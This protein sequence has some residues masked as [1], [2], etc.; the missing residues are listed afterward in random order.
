MVGHVTPWSGETRSQTAAPACQAR[1]CASEAPMSRASRVAPIVP[2]LLALYHLGALA[3]P[4]RGSALRRNPARPAAPPENRRAVAHP[5]DHHPAARSPAQR[6]AGSPGRA[7]RPGSGAGGVAGA[8]P[9][10]TNHRRR[11]GAWRRQRQGH[12]GV[13]GELRRA[14]QHGSTATGPDGGESQRMAQDGDLRGWTP[15]DVLSA[16]GMQEVRGSNPRSST[17]PQVKAKL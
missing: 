12:C 17:F 15:V 13:I 7:R 16:D 6:T 8:A 1:A 5:P 4:A 10:Q 3:A 2:R 9:R 11:Q 14:V